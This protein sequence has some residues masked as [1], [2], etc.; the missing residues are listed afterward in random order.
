M[1]FSLKY[2]LNTPSQQDN[3]DGTGKISIVNSTPQTLTVTESS[4]TVLAIPF[5][6]VVVAVDEEGTLELG[7][8]IFDCLK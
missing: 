2:A 7:P 8:E 1:R 3:N 6:D 5:W 4:F